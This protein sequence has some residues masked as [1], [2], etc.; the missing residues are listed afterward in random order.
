MVEVIVFV[1]CAAIVLGGAIGVV[2][3]NH[4]VHSALSLVATLFGIAVLFVQLE[5]HLL[6]AV[7]VIVYAGAIVILF[8]FVIMLLG[9]DRAEDLG[10][11]PIGGQRALAL[12]SGVGFLGAALLALFALAPAGI[13]TG[14]P[15]A[16]EAISDEVPNV[17]AVGE[18]L[19]TDYVAAFE[20]T[21]ILLTVAVV[22][23]V[24]LVRR[25][26]AGVELDDE[27]PT[28]LEVLEERKADKARR[29]IQVAEGGADDADD[30]SDVGD[31][32]SGEAGD[33]E[34]QAEVD[35]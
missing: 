3:S 17:E 27:G 26:P 12:A 25:R 6:A 28:A 35:R 34:A 31:D 21:A 5:A 2:A 29:R 13:V 23:A 1:A 33:D 10:D 11:E 30:P 18:L 16:I 8:L 20:I 15:G 32:P 24:M 7:Q 14:R 9:V 22:A 4:P 19:F